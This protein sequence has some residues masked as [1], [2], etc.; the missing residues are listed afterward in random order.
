MGTGSVIYRIVLLL[1]IIT[2]IVA[3]GGLVANGINNSRAF[4]SPADQAK[5][6]FAATQRISKPA[7]NALYA[8]FAL[9]IVLV[10]LSDSAIS[11]SAP[12]ISAAFLVVIV[13][14]GISHAMVRPNVAGLL[15]RAEALTVSGGESP[16]METDEEATGLAK[17]LGMG[18][19]I[20]QLLLIVALF[21][22]IWQP[23]N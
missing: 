22:M 4:K 17:R 13:M 21:L 10:A 5:T 8:L 3:F 14:I 16:V 2:A 6:L 20:I 9:G 1:H 12:W 7:Y 11:F 15:E 23:G 19:A 18:E